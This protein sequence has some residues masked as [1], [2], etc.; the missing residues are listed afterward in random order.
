MLE[1]FN[2]YNKKFK[3]DLCFKTNI[4]EFEHDKRIQPIKSRHYTMNI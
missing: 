4:N 2:Y 3:I 1:S